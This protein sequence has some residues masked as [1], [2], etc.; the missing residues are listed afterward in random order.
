MSEAVEYARNLAPLSRPVLFALVPTVVLAG[1]LQRSLDD[2]SAPLT[3]VVQDELPEELVSGSDELAAYIASTQWPDAVEGVILAQE[4]RFRDPSS[5]PVDDGAARPAL[6][7]SGVLR[8]G[9]ETTLLSI[10]QDNGA[11][12]LR[13]GDAVAPAVISALRYSLGRFDGHATTPPAA[14]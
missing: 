7:V 1:S 8:A 3:L 13:G 11:D 2:E 14:F 9:P 6:L 5:T 10:P 12:E 4:I